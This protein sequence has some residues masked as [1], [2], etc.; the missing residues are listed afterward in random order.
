MALLGKDLVADFVSIN[1][2]KKGKLAIIMLNIK[3]IL[4]KDE[5]LRTAED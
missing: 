4:A 5:V 3:L 2:K 1:I